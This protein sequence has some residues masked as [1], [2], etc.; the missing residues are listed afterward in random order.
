V[1]A[2]RSW[3]VVRNYEVLTKSRMLYSNTGWAGIPE[4]GAQM[5]YEHKWD[6]KQKIFEIS[7]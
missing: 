7:L 4:C 2:R 3:L 6:T 5:G 1:E